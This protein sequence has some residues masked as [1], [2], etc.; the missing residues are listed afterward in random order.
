M[1]NPINLKKI[2]EEIIIISNEYMKSQINHFEYFTT[3]SY[4]INQTS[5]NIA[6][7][8]EL[9]TYIENLLRVLKQWYEINMDAVP[10]FSGY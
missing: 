8:G 10:D 5:I 6:T 3:D 4:G 1:P 7:L 2:T 9:I